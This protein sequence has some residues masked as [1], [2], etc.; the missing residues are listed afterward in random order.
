MQIACPIHPDA[1]DLI[2]DLCLA[3]RMRPRIKSGAA[4]FLRCVMR[5]NAD[6]VP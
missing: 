2:R 6:R 3:P 1:P 5:F 4:C